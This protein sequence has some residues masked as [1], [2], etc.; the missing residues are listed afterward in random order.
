MKSPS[1]QIFKNQPNT[2]QIIPH[3]LSPVQAGFPS[4]AE[5]DIE[6]SIDLNEELI[7]SPA[8]TYFVKVRGNSM[9]DAHIFD[10]D[11]LIVDRSILPSNNR[12]VI[13]SVHQEFTVKRLKIINNQFYLVPENNEFKPLHIDQSDEFFIWGVVTYIIHKAK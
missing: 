2:S 9:Q 3:F 11:I 5:N 12:I 7:S 1:L 4:P 13:A 10:G 6:K 8:S